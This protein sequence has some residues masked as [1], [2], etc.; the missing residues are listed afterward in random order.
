MRLKSKANG[1]TRRAYR[2][3]QSIPS[4]G[5]SMPRSFSTASSGL[6]RS[7]ARSVPWKPLAILV[8][9]ILVLAFALTRCATGGETAENGGTPLAETGAEATSGRVS[10]V[11]V[12][13][14]L[15]DKV[16]G[17]Y[18]DSLAGDV[19]DGEYDYAP[20]YESIKPMVESAD[21]AYVKQET[22]IGGDEIGPLGWPSF[23]TT[24]DM[25][26]AIVDT[27]FDLVASASNHCY[28]WGSYGAVEHSREIWNASPVVYT[29]T[30]T[31]WEEANELALIERNGIT[32]ALLDYTYG[33]NGFTEADLEGYT[34]NFIDEDRIRSD[35]ER[36]KEASD[37]VM[38]AMHW[39]T[40]NVTE[41][42]DEQR[43]LAQL[44]ADLDVDLV[45]GSHP[46]VIQPMEW[47]EGASG[48]KTLVAYS[49]GN[50]LSHM[51]YAKAQNELEGS[52]SCTF[53]K[54]DEGNVSIEDVVWVPLVN[55]AEEGYHRII[56]LRDY[57]NEMA[58]KHRTLSGLEDPVAYLRE[59]DRS[60]MGDE[61]AIDDGQGDAEVAER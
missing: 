45:L 56:P 19:G 55:H 40:E 29:G 32:F 11:A 54:D 20:I 48:H 43:E 7:P 42:N 30:A 3:A 47:L 33:V 61:F 8:A 14:N 1:P 38:V 27:G 9:L 59:L 46:H 35:V 22:H 37:V 36:A 58:S 26:T 21:L 5:P 49:L 13:D 25:A 28:D 6:S 41:A 34:V 17:R 60:V 4:V 12:G 57:D 23:N 24:D 52:I 16:I 10:F 53:V 50:F 51:D 44:L 18:A 39:G 2:K 31:S 15:P